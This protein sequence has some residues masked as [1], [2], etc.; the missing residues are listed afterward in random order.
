MK[1][2]PLSQNEEA[3][4]DDEFFEQLNQFKWSYNNG[5]PHRSVRIDGKVK[6]I[7]LS[8]A[9][10][11]MAGVETDGRR[12]DHKD[13]NTLNN[14]RENLRLA[15]AVQNAANRGLPEN[16]TSG[17]KGVSF[18]KTNGKWLSQIYVSGY[19]YAIGQFDDPVT[20]ARAYD[21]VAVDWWGE[22]AW[23]N[24][25][26]EKAPVQPKLPGAYR[27]GCYVSP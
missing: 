21:A 23:L 4:V 18:I 1:K 2:L 20:A 22:F 17:Y 19:N 7:R 25:P 13:R 8:K 5:Y 14:Q 10:M 15:T 3:L 9:I 12:I 27:N 6:F 24:F 16:N 26:N 11:A